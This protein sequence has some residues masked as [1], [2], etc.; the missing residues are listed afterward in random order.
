MRAQQTVLLSPTPAP[1]EKPAGAWQWSQ[2]WHDLLFAHWQ[3]D[4]RLGAVLPAGVELDT[5][6]GAAWVS[7][8]AFRLGVRHRWLPPIRPFSNFVELNLRTYVV[9]RGEPGIFFLSIH[10]GSR[11]VVRLARWLTPLPYVF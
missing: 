1:R 3:V 7:V 8:V 4:D 5:R 10:A 11:A 9:R 2:D 6:D